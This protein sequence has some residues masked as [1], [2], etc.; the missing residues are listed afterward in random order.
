MLRKMMIALVAT[1][2]MGALAASTTADARMGGGGFRGG[3]MHM[4]GGGMRSFS[5]GGM[6][7]FSGGG[8]RTGFA[9]PR[10]R[11]A[12]FV[13]RPFIGPRHFAFRQA[14][15]PRFNRFA[16]ARV[17]RFHHR[18]FAFAAVPFV[19]GVGLYGGSLASF[20]SI[21]S[22]ARASSVGGRSMPSVLAVFRLI[23]NSYLVGACTGKSAGFS[24]LRMRAT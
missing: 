6:R 22:S 16:F 19:A 9:G 14:F 23:T 15:A 24:P 20:H 8:F 1:T 4:G 3:G 2:F 10:F 5:G 17:N 12:G 11:T 13:G 21:T 7:S 18:R